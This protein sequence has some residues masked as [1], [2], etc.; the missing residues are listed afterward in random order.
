[1]NCYSIV[2]SVD[3]ISAV[4]AVVLDEEEEDEIQFAVSSGAAVG[5]LI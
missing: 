3:I 4:V 5:C 2:V 1:M